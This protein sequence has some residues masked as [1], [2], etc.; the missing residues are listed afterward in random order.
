M[1]LTDELREAED[2]VAALKRRLASADCRVEGC[3]MQHS[4]GMNAACGEHCGCSVP[5]YTCTR[6]GDSDYGDN[7]EANAK[8]LECNE[9]PKP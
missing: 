3:D 4:G 6:C 9:E 8:R 1:S 2:R 5:V 7:P